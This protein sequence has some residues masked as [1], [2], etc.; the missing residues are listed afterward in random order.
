VEA[1]SLPPARNPLAVI[2]GYVLPTRTVRTDP[3][4]LSKIH[5]FDRIEILIFKTQFS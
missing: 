2:V 5:N 4:H 3:E 1:G